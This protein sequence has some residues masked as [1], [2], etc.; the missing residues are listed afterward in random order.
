MGLRRTAAALT[1]AVLAAVGTPLLAAQS[2]QDLLAAAPSRFAACDGARVRYKSLGGGREA[3]VFVHGWSCDLDFWRFQV[4]AFSRQTRLLLLDL[5]GFG[6]SAAPK[7]SYTMDLFARSVE[8]VMRDAGVDRAVLV[9][10]SMGTQVVRQFARLFPPRTLAL[11]AVDG[12]LRKF[13]GSPE[14][15]EK[16][17]A[18][19][20]T[21]QYKEAAAKFVDSMFPNPGTEALRDEARA[22]VV[23]TS[24]QAMVGGFGAMLD[25]AIWKDDAIRPP[26]L[27]VNAKSA[28]WGPDYETYVRSLDPDLEYH[29][30]EGAGHFLM[31]EKPAE[32]NAILLE[33]LAKK[34]LL[35]VAA[36]AAA[37]G[38]R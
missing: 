35:G 33:F 30:L 5:P 10:H 18:P 14:D 4:P 12:S 19:F 22:V 9:G 20:R 3:L 31:L 23:A 34:H 24:Q 32:F 28:F 1:L 36:R 21:A 8:A 7:G 37:G 26:L 11:V 38:S 27:V 13:G 17:V 25:P 2:A 16:L 15:V 29:T 6:E